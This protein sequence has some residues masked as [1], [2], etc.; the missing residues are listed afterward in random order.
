MPIVAAFLAYLFTIFLAAAVLTPAIRAL[1]DPFYPA[2]AGRYFRRV[3]EFAA[4]VLLFLFRKSMGIRSWRDVGFS[5]PILAP[6]L[7][8]CL[9]GL[10]SGLVCLLPLVLPSLSGHQ[11]GLRWDAV[12]LATWMGR[13]LL[14]ALTE[15]LLFRGIF[16]TILLRGLGRFPS[17]LASALLFCLAHYLRAAPTVSEG[18]PTFSSG[19]ELLLTHLAPILSFAWLDPRGLLLFSAGIALAAAYLETGALWFPVGIHA[20]WVTLLYGLAAEPRASSALWSALVIAAF[21]VLLWMRSGRHRLGG[22]A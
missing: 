15:E 2:P 11:A 3:L 22:V 9:L 6:F 12:S 18:P 8:G 19:W 13:G 4:L 10:V 5:R 7:W 14:V 17:I 1:L 20:L 21:G 16:F